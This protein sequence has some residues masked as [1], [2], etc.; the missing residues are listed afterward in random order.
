MHLPAYDRDALRALVQD[1]RDWCDG[2]PT[3]GCCER[4]LAAALVIVRFHPAL[5]YRIASAREREGVEFEAMVKSL[6]APLFDKP[7]ES[8]KLAKGMGET[9]KGDLATV[10][11]C[12][13]HA[14]SQTVDYE[15][16]HRW[17]ETDPNA[18]RLHRLLR[19]VLHKDPRFRCFP[20]VDAQFV[21]L[22]DLPDYRETAEL[23]TLPELLSI[24]MAQ[25]GP[26][27]KL[28]DRVNAILQEVAAETRKQ[29]AI[30]RE[31]LFLALRDADRKLAFDIYA[32]QNDT[33]TENIKLKL[34]AR[35]AAG[36]V[37]VELPSHLQ[38]LNDET[39]GDTRLSHIFT[40][41]VER[42]LADLVETGDHSCYWHYLQE[43][44]PGLTGE[45][46]RLEYRRFDDVALWAK[47]RF[48]EILRE[49]YG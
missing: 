31:L 43:F 27:K 46:Y 16:Y 9:V 12:F 30:P 45:S 40:K 48:S 28:A 8:G 35:E 21:G 2:T 24:V 34:A 7:G 32:E 47:G 3:K 1:I 20:S 22:A 4:L 25:A 19:E 11:L 41:A 5:H 15:L 18:A 14:V 23:W 13:R 49:F 37:M 42:L 33:P 26:H 39:G 10:V 36:K 6:V 17:R 44:V 29:A 38:K